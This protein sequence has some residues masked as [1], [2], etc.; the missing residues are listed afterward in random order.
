MAWRGNSQFVSN[1]GRGWQ[2]ARGTTRQ[3]LP[4]NLLQSAAGFLFW[5]KKLPQKIGWVSIWRQLTVHWWEW[6][7]GE[8]TELEM[9]Y[10]L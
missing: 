3:E 6:G 5:Q 2:E 10:L 7:E 4:Q 8:A 1:C 9:E